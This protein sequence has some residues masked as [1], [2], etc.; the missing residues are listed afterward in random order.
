M[1]SNRSLDRYTAH[2]ENFVLVVRAVIAVGAHGAPARSGAGHGPSRATS[3]GVGQS[4]TLV[5]RLRALP[6]HLPYPPY[7]SCLAGNNQP[8]R[9][10]SGAFSLCTCTYNRRFSRSEICVAVNSTEP[11]IVPLVA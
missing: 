11:L 8:Q 7:L 6:T 3:R 9:L 2:Y 5:D 4:P 10:P 1:R